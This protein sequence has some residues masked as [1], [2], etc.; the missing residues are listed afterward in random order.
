MRHLLLPI[1]QPDLIQR[2]DTRTQPAMHTEHPPIHDRAQAQ[3]VKHVAAVPPH[4]DRPVFA[5]ALVV[6]AV[7]LGDLAGLVVAADE[8]HAVGV[9]DFEGEEEEE[10]LDRVEAAVDKV[11]LKEEKRG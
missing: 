11:A 3:V 10:G 2:P 5:L 8:R 1:D 6:E 4:V 7:D 9:A